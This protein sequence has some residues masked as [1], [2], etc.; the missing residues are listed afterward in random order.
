MEHRCGT[1]YN[2]ELPASALT[3]SGVVSSVGWLRNISVS[4]GFFLT[5][6][7]VQ[8]FARIGLQLI[9]AQGRFGARLAGHVVRCVPQGLGIK[10]C[11]Y[12]SGLVRDLIQHGCVEQIDRLTHEQLLALPELITFRY[13][14][15]R[16]VLRDRA[17]ASV[18]QQ[19]GR[20]A[21]RRD[22]RLTSGKP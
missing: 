4:G 19:S 17:R 12:A 6:L 7:P 1:R 14:V 11:E 20:E 16:S 15:L 8:P 21:G 13:R 10:W 2:V 9:D 5:A 22:P 18:G 3:Y